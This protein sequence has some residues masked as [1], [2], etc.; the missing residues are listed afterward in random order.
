MPKKMEAAVIKQ[1]K[2]FHSV[3]VIHGGLEMFSVHVI[4]LRE[5]NK[6]ISA[7]NMVHSSF[8]AYVKKMHTNYDM[9][10]AAI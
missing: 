9:I 5:N 3:L 4:Y 8:L 10:F 7:N 2:C 6:T 1:L